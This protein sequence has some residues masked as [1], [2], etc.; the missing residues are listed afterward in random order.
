[1]VTE[2]ELFSENMQ[3]VLWLHAGKVEQQTEVSLQAGI[4]QR[5]KC[6]PMRIDRI[7]ELLS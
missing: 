3:S 2:D 5:T 6:W 7:K 1:M 4:T